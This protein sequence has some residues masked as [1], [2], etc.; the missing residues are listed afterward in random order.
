MLLSVRRYLSRQLLKQ[1][2]CYT[3]WYR[4][5]LQLCGYPKVKSLSL[6]VSRKYRHVMDGQTDILR[7]A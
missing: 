7:Q 6:A 2:Y 1:D 4:K 3:A 5:K